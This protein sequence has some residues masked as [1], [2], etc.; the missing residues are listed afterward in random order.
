MMLRRTFFLLSLGAATLTEAVQTG[1]RAAVTR[2]IAQHTD[3]NQH[4]ADGSTALLW[5]ARNDDADTVA[6]LLKAGAARSR[7]RS[8]PAGPSTEPRASWPTRNLTS[9]L[10]E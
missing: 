3:V 10:T 6:L 5:A 4:D 2:L 9:W 1:D 8:C 7:C